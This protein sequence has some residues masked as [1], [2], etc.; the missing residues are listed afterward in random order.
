MSEFAVFINSCD[1]F[2]DCWEPFF[3]LF[4]T[5]WPS[6]QGKLFLNTENKS[7]SYPGLEIVPLQVASEVSPQKKLT[8]GECTIRALREIDSEV[9]LYLQEDYFLNDYVN[10]E[11]INELSAL[12]INNASIHCLHITDQCPKA[13]KASKFE[14]LF[15]IP[16]RIQYRVSCQAA[17]WRKEI[18]LECLRPKET[19]WEFEKWGSKRAAILDHNFYAVDQKIVKKNE[20]EI[21]PYVTTGIIRGKWSKEVASLFKQ[22][23]I[24]IDLEK[25]GFFDR[26]EE[27]ESLK[28]RNRIKSKMTRYLERI[29]GYSNL[30]FL[31]VKLL[32]K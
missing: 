14:K 8:W 12:V 26:A 3:K 21:F 18:L 19:A 22:H 16:K 23:D 28:N 7:F 13:T 1:A 6:Y 32:F 15:Q 2:S 5:Y 11:L 29:V 17:F 27:S 30:F 24:S 31:R 9:V 25:R 10:E 20:F 4:K